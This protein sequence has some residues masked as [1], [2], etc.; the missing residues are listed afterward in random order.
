MK[1]VLI[2]GANGFI[3]KNLTKQLGRKYHVLPIS[4]KE[5]DLLDQKQVE[6]LFSRENIDVVIHSATQ[7]TL[8]RGQE[9]EEKLLKNNLAMFFNLE[10][11]KSAY[12]KL[13]VLGSG[14]EYGKQQE[15]SLV[16]ESAFGAVVPDDNY[17]LS[18]YAISKAMEQ[19]SN[20]YNLRLFGIFG[21]YE[22]YNYRFISN[23]ICKAL[24]GREIAIRQNV[25][26][27]YLYSKD[28]CRILPWFM[29]HEPKYH[30]YNVCTGKRIDIVSI[31][32]EILAQT[33]SR[34]ILTVKQQG[35]NREYTGSNRQ[36]LLETG[37]VSFTP[38][39]QAI[40][41]MIEFYQN[42]TFHLEGNY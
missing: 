42:T 21:P 19:S 31:A 40:A 26:F 9:Y 35:F 16:E 30:A 7:N 25:L 8:G 6:R 13:F 20:I 29:E 34:S 14:A 24:L 10:R 22:N 36:M 39:N 32:R 23:V 15:L 27:D 41:E 4:R 11:C 38:M 28:F 2:T 33:G 17:G 3:G 37:P 18:K 5:A 1:T 12:G